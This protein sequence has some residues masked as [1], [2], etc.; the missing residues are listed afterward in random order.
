MS[1][2]NKQCTKC[3]I[4]KNISEF[5]KDKYT[6]SGY[7]H[8]CKTCLGGKDNNT[9]SKNNSDKVNYLYTGFKKCHRCNKVYKLCEFSFDIK[10]LDCLSHICK[11]CN[12]T[13]STCRKNKDRQRYRDLQ[14]IKRNTD[15]YREKQRK[16]DSKRRKILKN[17]IN[18]NISRS[19]R[20]CLK[21]N[22]YDGKKRKWEICVGYTLKELKLHL[23]SLFQDG[24]AWENYGEWEMDHIIPISFFDIK[25]INDE[26]F[27]K[28]WELNNLQPLWKF[29]NKIKG[30]KIPRMPN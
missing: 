21:I 24:M 23:E 8:K 11:K 26:S 18:N 22:K 2:K 19:I 14:K 7:C 30:S 16:Y 6:K 15:E 28:C 20:K 27:K 29:E 1:I 10:S 12:N 3:K 5:W 25:D 4:T 9:L 17:K 13:A